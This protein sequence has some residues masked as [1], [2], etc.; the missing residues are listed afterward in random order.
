MITFKRKI[1]LVF[2]LFFL[3]FKTGA[4][5]VF[6]QAPWPTEKWPRSILEE[7]QIAP[8]RWNDLVRRIRHENECPH[9]HS[10]IVVKNGYLVLEEYFNGYDAETLNSLQSVT[11]SFTSA[12]MGIAIEQ[13]KIRGVDE[14]VLDFFLDVQDIQNM[15]DRKASM[16]FRDLLTMRSGTDYDEG[17]PSSPH[18]Q[19]N[20]LERGWDRFYLNRPMISEPGTRFRYDSG[21]VILM[22]A[23]LKNRTGDHVDVFAEKYLFAPLGI[24]KMRWIK[25]REGHPH[26]GGGLFMRPL[27]VAKFGLLYLRNGK[28]EDKQV[29]PARWVEESFKKHVTFPGQRGR[30]TTGYGYLWWLQEPDPDG[31]GKS[32]IVSARGLGGQYI[33]II[34]EHRM[35]VVTTSESRHNAGIQ[36]PITILYRDILPAMHD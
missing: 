32:D 24:R 25:N 26:T 35:V 10:L 1:T 16:T 2:F 13:G 14:K 30:K 7:Q 20:R 27:D 28:W 4:S 8:E 21:G 9:L 15:D 19:M 34:P 33:F 5:F 17:Y 23:M 36:D 29:V 18:S 31:S 12:V 11:K 22:S 6:G 3:L